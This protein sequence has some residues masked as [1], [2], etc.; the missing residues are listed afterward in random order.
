MRKTG[1]QNLLQYIQKLCRTSKKN[2]KIAARQKIRIV[3]FDEIKIL[4]KFLTCLHLRRK[5]R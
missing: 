1:L 2:I 3:F 4:A 5:I